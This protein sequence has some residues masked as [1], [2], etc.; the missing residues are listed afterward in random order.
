MLPLYYPS[1][2][3]VAFFRPWIA[4]QGLEGADDCRWIFGSEPEWEPFR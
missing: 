1:N 4:A 3:L 2:T